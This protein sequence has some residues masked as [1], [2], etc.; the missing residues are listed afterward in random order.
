MDALHPQVKIY[1]KVVIGKLDIDL[2]IG[3]SHCHES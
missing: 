3:I 2:D 1:S